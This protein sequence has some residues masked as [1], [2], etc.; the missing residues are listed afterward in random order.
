MRLRLIADVLYVVDESARTSWCNGGQKV[1]IWDVGESGTYFG[2]IVRQRR[3][4]S[5]SH[6][7]ELRYTYIG[8]DCGSSVPT[9]LHLASLCTH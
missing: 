9:T 1:L 2:P 3:G 4:I 5:R 6:H 7:V 8:L